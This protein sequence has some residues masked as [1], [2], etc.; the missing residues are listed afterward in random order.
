MLLVYL[1]MDT[2]KGLSC[3]LSLETGILIWVTKDPWEWYMQLSFCFKEVCSV[4]SL[5]PFVTYSYKA[6]LFWG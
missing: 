4:Y 6:Y 2:K 5:S 3:A 1:F